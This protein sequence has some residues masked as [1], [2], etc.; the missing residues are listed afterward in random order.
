[1]NKIIK[2]QLSRCKISNIPNFNDSTTELIIPKAEPE[3]VPELNHAYL[4]YI[5]DYIIHE[6]PG[7]QLSSNW[8]KGT[9]PK[10]SYYRVQVIQIVGKMYKVQGVGYN[11]ETDD[12]YPEGWMG[13][14]PE[15]GFHIK[16]EI[17]V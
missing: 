8:N 1:M 3:K 14:L 5:E 2:E 17:T 4:I 7:F 6:P 13:W 11:P 10:Y 9:C 15:K 16:K 12:T